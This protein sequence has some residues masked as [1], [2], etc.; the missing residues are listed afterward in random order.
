MDEYGTQEQ[1]EEEEATEEIK[2]GVP[3]ASE[4]AA[5]AAPEDKSGKAAQ[6]ALMQA[7]ER[8]TGQVTTETYIKYF[9]HAGR[10]VSLAA[11][12]GQR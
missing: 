12:G 10:F 1:A 8:V 11:A 4:K 2:P 3:V 9:N 6:K 5:V 7:E